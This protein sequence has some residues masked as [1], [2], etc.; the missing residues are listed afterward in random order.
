[1][2]DDALTPAF[3]D[4]AERHVAEAEFSFGPMRAASRVDVGTRGIW[5]VAGLVSVT[6][7]GVAAIVWASTGPARRRASK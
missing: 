4:E 7:V 1:M 3:L 6:L 2:R 5:A